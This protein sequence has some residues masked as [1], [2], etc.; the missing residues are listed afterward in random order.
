[1]HVCIRS[2]GVAVGI[3]VGIAAALGYWLACSDLP[4]PFFIILAVPGVSV[5]GA[6]GGGASGLV[7]RSPHA[8]A[9]TDT[10]PIVSNP[11][12][13]VRDSAAPIHIIRIVRISISVSLSQVCRQALLTRQNYRLPSQHS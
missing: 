3:A 12:H 8:A 1:M 11:G 6:G 13:V 9:S 4:L 5:T 10:K 2:L 7:V